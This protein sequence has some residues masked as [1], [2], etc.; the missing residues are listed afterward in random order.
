MQAELER[1]QPPY[2]PVRRG[3]PSHR[4][5]WWLTLFVV[6]FGLAAVVVGM[7]QQPNSGQRAVDLA[8]Y[9]KTLNYDAQS[10]AGGVRDSFYVLH[11][12]DAGAS[13]DT[14]TAISV[15]TGAA[16]NCQPA[17]S[18]LI[19]NL[20][21]EQPS[22]S[23][24][25]FH[26]DRAKDALVTWAIVDATQVASDIATVLADRGRPSEAAARTALATARARLDNQ[27]SMVTSLLAPAVKALAPKASLLALPG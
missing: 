26:V 18:D 13:T 12:I 14:G 8:S 19:V 3:W 24:A 1:D 27:R 16:T 23:L 11:A 25:S 21:G 5:P 17:S 2:I 7:T 4:S 20:A 15:A 6:A 10:C 22:E 9:I